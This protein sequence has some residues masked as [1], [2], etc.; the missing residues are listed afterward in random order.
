MHCCSGVVTISDHLPAL[1]PINIARCGCW[2]VQLS[3]GQLIWFAIY[4][5]GRAS[6]LQA[7]GG[8]WCHSVCL[9]WRQAD[10]CHILVICLQF[11]LEIRWLWW[12]AWESLHLPISMPWLQIHRVPTVSLS[13]TVQVT[14]GWLTKWLILQVRA[15]RDG[16]KLTPLL[17]FC[18]VAVWRL[19]NGDCHL[20]ASTFS[21]YHHSA[22][23]G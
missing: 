11:N 21:S 5:Q 20:I 23:P 19:N 8:P 17:T 13:T 2:R 22:R 16:K 10:V 18:C 14:Q 15:Q 12:T 6:C 4:E 9:I 1:D 7:T 3:Q